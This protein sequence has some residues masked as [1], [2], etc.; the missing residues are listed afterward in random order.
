MLSA[1]RG[2]WPWR[3]AAIVFFCVPIFVGLGRTDLGNDEA[4]Y[5]FAVDKILETGDWLTPR[6]SPRVDIAFLEKPPLKFWIVAAPIKVGI[7]PRNEFGFRFWD[8]FMGAIA[9]LYV[10]AIARRLGGPVCAFVSVLLLFVHGPL[11]FQHGLRSNN[12]EAPLLLA[13]AGG[14]YHYLGWA[15]TSSRARAA[16]HVGAVTGYFVL[17]FMT[18]FVAV[19]FLPVVIALT[20]VF[21]RSDRQRLWDERRR[22]VAAGAVTVAVVSPWFLY[23]WQRF[24]ADLWAIMFGAHVYTRFTRSLDPSHVQP[25]HFYISTLFAEL[26]AHQSLA[27]V[28]PGTVVLLGQTFA[29]PR[30]ENV[31]I[32]SWFA[33]PVLLMSMG[34]SKLYHYL[35]PFLP[36][37]ALGGGLFAA[38]LLKV[39]PAYLRGP[40]DRLDAVVSRVADVQAP[41]LRHGTVRLL[42]NLVAAASL[43]LAVWTLLRGDVRLAIGKFTLLRNASSTR[44]LVYALVFAALARR[45]RVAVLLAGPVLVAYLSPL[46]AYE[47]SWSSLAKTDH[48][49]RTARDCLLTLQAGGAPGTGVYVDVP[50]DRVH[51]FHHYYLDPVGP[52]QQPDPR[53]DRELFA[54]LFMSSKQQPVLVSEP[55]YQTLVSRLQ[56]RDPELIR[57]VEEVERLARTDIEYIAEHSS[58]PMVPLGEVLLILPGE[59]SACGR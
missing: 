53:S 24:G 21:V 20:A 9:F 22:W 54:R 11:L 44:P 49:L 34:S 8:A 30:R 12:M 33:V 36:P 42:L 7:L 3:L 43:V 40:A 14:L 31:L 59:F 17:G 56:N 32:L 16:G 29:A 39:L 58:T 15:T 13:Y 26:R 35:Y 18:K 1:L 19:L 4:I 23:Q 5:S 48:P 57:E 6:T 46:A 50:A 41:W 55:R 51:H 10:F 2:A 37:V 28:V 25:W 45:A 52:W 38:V 47:G 27:L